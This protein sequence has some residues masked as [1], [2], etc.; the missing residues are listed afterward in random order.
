MTHPSQAGKKHGLPANHPAHPQPLPLFLT[1]RPMTSWPIYLEDQRGLGL[2]DT[3]MNP[4]FGSG[5]MEASGLGSLT[6]G[7]TSPTILERS[8]I[9]SSTGMLQDTGMT[10][11]NILST[12]SSV[13]TTHLSPLSCRPPDSKPSHHSGSLPPL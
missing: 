13:S 12:A 2:E 5:L 8:L 10:I 6:G 4:R 11:E 1:R 9:F 7:K 3:K